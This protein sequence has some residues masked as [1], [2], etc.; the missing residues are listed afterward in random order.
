VLF[1]FAVGLSF[2]CRRNRELVE[3]IDTADAARVDVGIGVS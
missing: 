2:G 3:D 1:S